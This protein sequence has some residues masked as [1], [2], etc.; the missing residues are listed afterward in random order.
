ME[1]R[2]DYSVVMEVGVFGEC[3]IDMENPTEK[4]I[5]KKSIE[6]EL[7]EAIKRNKENLIK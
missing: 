3:G 5:K 1:K 2:E 7:D 4:K 6:T